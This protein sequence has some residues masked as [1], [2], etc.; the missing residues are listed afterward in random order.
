MSD[1]SSNQDPKWASVPLNNDWLLPTNQVH[2][3][4]S[5]LEL[6]IHQINNLKHLLSPDELEKATHL[7]L[8]QKRHQYIIARAILRRIL[9]LYVS[10]HPSELRFRYNR[11]GKPVLACSSNKI[12]FNVSHSHNLAIYALSSDCL[13]G[14]DVEYLYRRSRIDRMKIASRLFT[15][16][17]YT[18]LQSLPENQRDKAFLT[19]WTRKE[20]FIKAMGWGLSFPLDKF[21]VTADP[22]ESPKLLTT[23]YKPKDALDW[24][25]VPIDPS[26]GYVGTLALRKTN[27]DLSYW[28][29]NHNF[30]EEIHK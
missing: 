14:V 8:T 7:A 10:L 21:E 23:P 9:S 29:W 27:F 3:W 17:E 20:A 13:I 18:T 11:N 30:I 1:D 4:R 5:T 22:N 28:Q 2:I 25:M 15:P 6:P 12:Q 16:R 19:C 24:S 26:D